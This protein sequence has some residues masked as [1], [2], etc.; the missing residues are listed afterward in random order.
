MPNMPVTT[1]D[2]TVPG[3]VI[4]TSQSGGIWPKTSHPDALAAWTAVMA[5]PAAPSTRMK[6]VT[7]KNRAMSR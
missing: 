4:A 2:S 6:A 1:E 7:R 5:K 3:G